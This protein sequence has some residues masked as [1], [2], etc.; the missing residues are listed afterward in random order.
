MTLSS[1]ILACFLSMTPSYETSTQT[2]AFL[3]TPPVREAR[4]IALSGEMG[5]NGLSG[6]GLLLS[7]SPSPHITFDSGFG[8]S[9]SGPKVGIQGRYNVLKSNATPYVGLGLGQSF[10]S[11]GAVEMDGYSIEI[12]PKQTA[13]ASF[14]LSYVHTNGFTMLAGL[15]YALM[16]QDDPYKVVSGRPSGE[17]RDTLGAIL[18]N[19]PV[20]NIALGYS[21]KA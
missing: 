13:H 12:T 11:Y 18:G 1:T 6:S 20:V 19:G 8:F 2:Q 17:Q 5:W 21:F 7:W 3:P 16:L 15:G 9:L 14:G 4:N 10:G